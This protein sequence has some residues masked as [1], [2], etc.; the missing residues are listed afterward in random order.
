MSA[1]KG[2][3]TPISVFL[4]LSLTHVRTQTPPTPLPLYTS[5]VNVSV[6]CLIENKPQCPLMKTTN[7][8]TQALKMANHRAQVFVILAS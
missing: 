6:G 1:D 3:N 5:V 2:L 4:S 7:K 8:S